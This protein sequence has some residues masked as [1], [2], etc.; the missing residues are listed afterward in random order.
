MKPKGVHGARTRI[1][2]MKPKNVRMVIAV[3]AALYF[4]LHTGQM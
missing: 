4:E 1:Q 2:T 3:P